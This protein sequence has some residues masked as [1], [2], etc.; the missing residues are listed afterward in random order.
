MKRIVRQMGTLLVALFFLLQLPMVALA[1]ELALPPEEIVEGG[2]I[3]AVDDECAIA[4]SED[5]QESSQEQIVVEKAAESPVGKTIEEAV[6][7]TNLA[8]AIAKKL[9]SSEANITHVI[10]DADVANLATLTVNAKGIASL[11][12]IEGF[13]NLR[14]VKFFGNDF[15]EFPK[16]LLQLPNLKTIH[17]NNNASMVGP[18]PAEISTLTQLVDFSVNLSPVDSV[19]DSIVTLTNLTDL[20]LAGTKTTQLPDNF[21]QLTGLKT[22]YLTNLGLKE[23]PA[24]LTSMTNLETVQFRYN[25][26][27]NITV[28]DYNFIKSRVGMNKGFEDQFANTV[29]EAIHPVGEAYTLS[30]PATYSTLASLHT[31][32]EI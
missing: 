16:E 18:I 19:P 1:E 24:G 11:A 20:N 6:A 17:L 13:Q 23:L 7:D 12:G 21:A 15:T 25:A 14:S 4:D 5:V 9:T 3:E 29:D 31:D 22:L 26:L 2:A 27:L 28:E 30:E 32:G 10:T 8:A